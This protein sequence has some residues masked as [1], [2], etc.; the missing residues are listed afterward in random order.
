[1]WHA[2]AQAAA[3]SFPPGKWSVGALIH[4]QFQL[5]P[6]LALTASHHLHEMSGHI[7]PPTEQDMRERIPRFFA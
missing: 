6:V 2:D 1:M 7:K 3:I 4:N 5:F